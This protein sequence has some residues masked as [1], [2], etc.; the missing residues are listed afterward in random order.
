[1]NS[2]RTDDG[3]TD[4]NSTNE[5]TRNKKKEKPA[6]NTK[7]DTNTDSDITSLYEYTSGDE[8]GFNINLNFTGEAWTAK[9]KEQAY[10][11]V[12]LLTALIIADV[13]D[14]KYKGNMIDDLSL[15]L[16]IGSVD[17]SGGVLGNAGVMKWRKDSRIPLIGKIY[18]DEADSERLLN[19]GRFDDLILHEM[20]HTVGFVSSN[21]ALQT[22]V[23]EDN[24][25]VGSNGQ[26]AYQMGV[27]N[28]V[29]QPEYDLLTNWDTGFHWAHDAQSIPSNEIMS[30]FIYD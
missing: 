30:P 28:G 6:K 4:T 12:E 25:Y 23:D 8:N 2:A 21:A 22:L 13:P 10:S 18:L 24:N 9:L 26:A 3:S 11:I 14:K 19:Q 17:G 27:V 5:T 15:D 1:M 20:I 16:E 7:A 29:Y